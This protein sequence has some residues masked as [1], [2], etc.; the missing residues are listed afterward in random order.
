MACAIPTWIHAKNATTQC[1]H[2]AI[3]N[4]ADCQA[5]ICSAHI[6]ECEVCHKF[7]CGDCISEHRFNH[8]LQLSR[9]AA[10]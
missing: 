10:A 5:G 7:I 1:A 6:V 8:D 3:T 4:C 2:P 9:G